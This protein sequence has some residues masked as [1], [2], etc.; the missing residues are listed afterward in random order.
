MF[1]KE[2]EKFLGETMIRCRKLEDGEKI[3]EKI[4]SALLLCFSPMAEKHT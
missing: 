3:L 1:K 2:S 4:L